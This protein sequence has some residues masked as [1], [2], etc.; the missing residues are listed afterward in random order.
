MS[1]RPLRMLLYKERCCSIS[2]AISLD[3]VM[4]RMKLEKM[5]SLSISTWVMKSSMSNGSPFFGAWVSKTLAS[6]GPCPVAW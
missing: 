2:A 3:S 1:G 4:S 6:T 5:T